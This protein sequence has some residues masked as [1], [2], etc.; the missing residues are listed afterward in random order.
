MALLP[1]LSYSKSAGDVQSAQE[2]AGIYSGTGSPEGV[3]PAP[4][5]T[6]YVDLDTATLYCK[7]AGEGATG[8]QASGGGGG[9]AVDSVNGQTGVV[10]LDAT[11]VGAVAPGDL[12]TVATTGAYADLTGKPVLATVATSGAYS[13]LSGTPAAITPAALTKVDDTNVTAT[14]GG[15]PATALLQAAS[16]TLGWAGQLS[17]ARGGSGAATLTGYVKGTGTTAFT[18]S[19]SIPYADLT[20]TPTIPTAA[21]PTGTVGLAAVNGSAGTFMRS[22][23]APP[24]DQALAPTWTGVHTFTNALPITL[25]SAEPRLRLKETDQTTDETLWDVDVSAKVW[26]VRSRTDADG[27]GTNA[28]AITRGTGTAITTI[29][30]G[31]TTNNPGF[32]FLGNGSTTHTGSVQA[33]RFTVAGS[34]VGSNSIYLP[35]TNRLG[36]STNSQYRGEFDASGQFIIGS[37]GQ[38]LS[39]KEG[40]N[41]K[42]GLATLSGGTVVVSTTAV[43]AN[44]RIFLTAQ[45]LGTV[46][47]P[48]GYGVSARTAGTSFTILASAP[49][50][51]STVAWMIVEPSP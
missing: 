32:T 18:A 40:S 34:T 45:S 6:L 8:W 27:A 39:V 37:L 36:F 24:I 28:I 49:T 9:G 51:T 7:T 10:S 14:L 17:V 42:M 47:V 29:A 48:S 16:I 43:T 3:V 12:A 23:G 26:T 2:Y 21:N 50:D 46:A 22:D 11:D 35:G 41:A 20:G 30:L 1:G 19:A 15:T 44:S 33:S 4:I 31:N 13:D 38:G 5:S 25:S